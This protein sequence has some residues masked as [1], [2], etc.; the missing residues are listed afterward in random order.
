MKQRGFLQTLGM[1]ALAP[2][3]SAG[4]RKGPEPDKWADRLEKIFPNI[5]PDEIFHWAKSQ[6][7]N[8]GSKNPSPS[9]PA[10]SKPDLHAQLRSALQLPPL[11]LS[12]TAEDQ[13]N[14][15]SSIR[16]L[17]DFLPA[18]LQTSAHLVTFANGAKMPVVILAPRQPSRVP[19]PVFCLPGHGRG[20]ADL[21]NPKGACQAFPIRLAEAGFT[22]IC[23]ELPGFGCRRLAGENASKTHAWMESSLRFV[24][25]S[26]LGYCLW[27]LMSL[28]DW[29]R[30]V[31]AP[32]PALGAW[33]WSLGAELAMLWGALDTEIHSTCISAFVSSYLDSFLSTPHCGC[34]YVHGLAKDWTQAEILGL[35]APRPAC[36][37]SFRGDIFPLGAAERTVAEARQRYSAAG[38]P[39]G[40]TQQIFDGGHEVRAEEGV[41]WFEKVLP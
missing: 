3:L 17:P 34:G 14:V 33:G 22:A 23:P 19:T 11:A 36:V 18:S 26:F 13:E 28:K 21:L 20:L 39:N 1:A 15:A 31:G 35:I 5:P 8:P 29:V 6:A 40:L 24:G 4:C 12:A 32:A 37:Q 9:S 7:R 25:V 41:R 38:N 30:R 2:F 27:E 16:S 10:G